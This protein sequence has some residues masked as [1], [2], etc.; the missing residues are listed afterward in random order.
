MATF[1]FQVVDATRSLARYKMA[2]EGVS[3]SGKTLSALLLGYGFL[4][5]KFPKLTDAQIWQKICVIDTENGSGVLYKGKRVGSTVIGTYKYIKFPPPFSAENYRAA[6][7]AAEAAGTE[8]LIIDSFSH[9]WSGVGGALDKQGNIAA[10]SGNSYTAWRDVTP[11][12]NALVDKILQCNMDVCVTMRT[13]NEYV[14]EKN[15]KGK[16]VPRKVG[17]A[18]IMRDGVEYEFTTV[19]D[20]DSR[21]VASSSKDRT[22]L[23]DG[24]FEVLEPKH[25]QMM[26]QWL[27]DSADGA[28]PA[29]VETP[30]VE[31]ADT[32]TDTGADPEAFTFMMDAVDK[33][34][35]KAASTMDKAALTAE[36]KAITGG[37][38]NYKKIT[39]MDTL[40]ALYERF[41]KE[42]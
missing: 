17:T 7:D 18:P 13:K 39:D 6:I 5:A 14:I 29:P 22:G 28:D 8:F 24:Q 33:G 32:D 27:K 37:V 23:F 34:I 12:H 25:G 42:D 30:K 1:N 11:E 21:H 10:R 2:L 26:Y 3:G 9:A 38:A 19:L 15:D 31:D 4:K 41:A 40:N 20:I 36:I 35:R 16:S